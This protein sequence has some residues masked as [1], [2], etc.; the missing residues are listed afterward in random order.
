[1]ELLDVQAGVDVYMSE[2]DRPKEVLADGKLLGCWEQSR[3]IDGSA[4]GL[5]PGDAV[6]KSAQLLHGCECDESNWSIE[7]VHE[8][9]QVFIHQSL[10]IQH[11]IYFHLHLIVLGL[12]VSVL[13]LELS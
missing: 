7:V 13:S 9:I 2:A 3:P 6:Q 8:L 11:P 12:Q 4:P 5:R 1:M 10:C